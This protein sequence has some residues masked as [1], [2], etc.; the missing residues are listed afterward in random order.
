M[1]VS[2]ERSPLVT[3][4]RGFYPDYIKVRPRFKKGSTAWPLPSPAKPKFAWPI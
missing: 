4:G 2:N 3:G 1:E